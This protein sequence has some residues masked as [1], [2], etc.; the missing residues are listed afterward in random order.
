MA[1]AILS[2]LLK[3]VKLLNSKYQNEHF[4]SDTKSQILNICYN[5]FQHLLEYLWS[6][7]SRNVINAEY[8]LHFFYF[9][10]KT[11]SFNKIRINV[12]SFQ[13]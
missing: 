4:S 13:H 10:L 6:K 8:I 2:N 11:A 12:L 5:K 3:Y 7:N 1:R 9:V